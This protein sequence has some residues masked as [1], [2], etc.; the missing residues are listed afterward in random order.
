MRPDVRLTLANR[1]S[2]LALVAALIVSGTGCTQ[3][4]PAIY[5]NC[6]LVSAKGFSP[7]ETDDAAGAKIPWVRNVKTFTGKVPI[8]WAGRV[9]SFAG[10]DVQVTNVADTKLEGTM[11]YKSSLIEQP[12]GSFLLA[13]NDILFSYTFEFNRLSDELRVM[14]IDNAKEGPIKVG[15]LHFTCRRSGHAL[16]GFAGRWP[17]QTRHGAVRPPMPS[18]DPAQGTALRPQP[19]EQLSLP[20]RPPVGRFR[21]DRWSSPRLQAPSK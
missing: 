12:D 6:D 8:G 20:V 1:M 7:T 2:E 21:P 17:S 4:D 13:K 19:R 10:T 15:I 11:K 5:V 14:S 18:P 9:G 16:N 3:F